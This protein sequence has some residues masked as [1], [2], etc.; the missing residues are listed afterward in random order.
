M[1]EKPQSAMIGAFIVGALLISISALIFLNSTGFGSSRSKVV[2]VF[3]GSVKGLTLGAPVALRGVQIGQVTDIELI[4]NTDSI[5]LTMLVEAELNSDNIRR[6]GSTTRNLTEDLI[7]SGLRAQL[8]SQSILTGLLYIQ[9]D[10][11]P[12]SDLRLVDIDSDYT[13]IPTIRTELERFT[14]EFQKVDFTQ[15]A[16]DI[17]NITASIESFVSDETLRQLPQDLRNSLASLDAMTAQITTMTE[18]SGPKLNQLLETSTRTMEEVNTEIPQLA[19]S[20]KETL[21][22]LNT[23][24]AAFEQ[25]MQGISEVVSD[26]STTR[27][28]LDLALQEMARAGRALQLLAKTLEEQPDA[29]IRGRKED[30]R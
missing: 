21:Q 7:A 1:S 11:H 12:D 26:D 14:Q 13:Q 23:A 15:L 19:N 20:A 28:Q 9:L 2:M 6:V 4:L 30:T 27:Y 17:T 5:D 25:A 22:E 10:F 29:L 18:A 16:A 3:S 8:N 24:A